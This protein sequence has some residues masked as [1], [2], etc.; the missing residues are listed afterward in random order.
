MYQYE[1]YYDPQVSL[2]GD[3]AVVKLLLETGPY[4]A[5]YTFSLSKATG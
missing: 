3:K 1:T 5:D 2:N 4:L